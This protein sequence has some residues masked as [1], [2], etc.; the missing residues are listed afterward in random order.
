MNNGLM[1]FPAPVR[2]TPQLIVDRARNLA[3]T[4]NVAW[5]GLGNATDGNDASWAEAI[6][7]PPP[8]I[9]VQVD[10]GAPRT[11][12]RCRC[13][14]IGD[15]SNHVPRDGSILY[16]MDGVIWRTAFTFLSNTAVERTYSFNAYGRYWRFQTDQTVGVGWGPDFNTLSFFGG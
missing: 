15:N 12:I 10:L 7:G 4:S 5:N 14:S 2:P 16:S 3:L 1:G 11:I 8:S 6:V 9:W 13:F